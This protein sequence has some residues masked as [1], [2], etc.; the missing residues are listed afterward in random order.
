M[1][2]KKQRNVQFMLCRTKTLARFRL[3]YLTDCEAIN[4]RNPFSQLFATVRDS[5]LTL[6]EV[7]NITRPDG[8]YM[9]MGADDQQKAFQTA[10]K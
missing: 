1:V 5:T 9:N 10:S 3:F 2:K 8:I 6:H 7:E 4:V